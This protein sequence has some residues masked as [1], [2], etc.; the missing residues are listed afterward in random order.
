MGTA[1]CYPIEQVTEEKRRRKDLF[2]LKMA[3][4]MLLETSDNIQHST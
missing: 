4:A 1:G 2:A 3:N